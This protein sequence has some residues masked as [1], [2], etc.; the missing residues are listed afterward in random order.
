MREWLWRRF[1]LA[2][3]RLAKI[4]WLINLRRPS[5]LVA[6]ASRRWVRSAQTP[7]AR[8]DLLA[9]VL[10]DLDKV[11]LQLMYI[12]HDPY[13]PSRDEVTEVALQ[14]ALARLQVAQLHATRWRRNQGIDEPPDEG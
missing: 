7:Q 1:M 8:R 3:E 6:F 4:M 12:S 9:R 13:A 10:S 14:A 5:R 11:S 2:V